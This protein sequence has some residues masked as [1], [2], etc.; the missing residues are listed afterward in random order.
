LGHRAQFQMA[1]ISRH[2]EHHPTSVS[3]SKFKINIRL[4]GSSCWSD[5]AFGSVATGLLATNPAARSSISSERQLGRANDRKSSEESFLRVP[6]CCSLRRVS[7]F[8]KPRDTAVILFEIAAHC[9]FSLRRSSLLLARQSSAF[10][11]MR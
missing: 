7:L 4:M 11:T 10:L 1:W 9:R 3:S 5:F 6:C 2:D 8:K